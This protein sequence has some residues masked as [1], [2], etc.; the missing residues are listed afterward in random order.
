MEAQTNPPAVNC[1]QTETPPPAQGVRR[2]T[3]LTKEAAAAA[4]AEAARLEKSL[5]AL[6]GLS[7]AELEKAVSALK[8]ELDTCV[9]GTVKKAELKAKLGEVQKV[10]LEAA[11]KAAAGNKALIV[12]AAKV[13]STLPT[14]GPQTATQYGCF[15]L[16]RSSRGVEQRISAMGK[17]LRH[18]SKNGLAQAVDLL[19]P[20]A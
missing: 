10:L 4:N 12:A 2:I 13:G 3:G 19:A 16:N 9:V 20:M 6:S 14:L 15:T 18:G 1:D 11:K 5:A 7:G 8:V 17:D